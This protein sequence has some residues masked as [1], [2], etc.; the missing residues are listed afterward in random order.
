MGIKKAGLTKKRIFI[1][2]IIF[3]CLIFVDYVGLFESINHYLYDFSFRIRGERE[4]SR[5]IILV[6]ID[7]RTLERLGRWPI[8]R[9]FYATLIERLKQSSAIMIDIIMTEPTKDDT[10]LSET[11]KRHGKVFLPVY[12]DEERKI[13]Y[14]SIHNFLGYT[15]H[16]H[17]EQDIDGVVRTVYHTLMVDNKI[18]PS[19]ASSLYELLTGKPFKREKIGYGGTTEGKGKIL[20]FDKMRINFAGGHGTF[21]TISFIDVLDGIY[22]PDFFKNRIVIVGL[23]ATGT[24]DVMLTPFIKH[25]K[26]MPGME[27]QA[28]ILNTLIFDNAIMDIKLWIR[29]LIAL[30]IAFIFHIFFMAIDEKKGV[31]IGFL[32]IVSILTGSYFLFTRFNI[33]L[34]PT[35]YM[36]SVFLFF[37]ISYVYKFDDAVKSLHDTYTTLKSH[38]RWKIIENEGIK[39]QRGILSILS[40][41]GINAQAVVLNEIGRQLNFEKELSDRALMSGTNGV[42]LFEENG[43]NML[44]NDFG[45]NILKALN[46]E[47]TTIYKFIEAIFPYLL[48]KT[49]LEAVKRLV[50]DEK[51]PSTYTLGTTDKE[52]KFYKIDFSS[53]NI[54]GSPYFLVIITDIT[55]I[56]ELELLKSHIISVVSH[57]LKGPMTS[58]QGFSEILSKN[59]TG[60]MQNFAHIINRESERLVRFLNT[61]L[62]ITRIEEGRQPVRISPVNLIEV[63]KE[64]AHASTP[65][66]DTNKISI[67]TEVPERIEDIMIDRDLT[68][69][70]IFNLVEN[71]IK[72]SPPERDVI[73]RLTDE[74]YDVRVDVIDHGYG[75]REED[76]GRIFDKFFRSSSPKTKNIKGSGLGL[77]FVKEAVELQGGRLTL[78]SKYNEGS[79]FSIIF[80]KKGQDKIKKG[81]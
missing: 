28:N 68:K 14:P 60:K 19:I 44:T 21:D 4:C 69:Q 43:N 70:C 33:W 30:L 48:E 25:R 2:F 78:T 36:T 79:V 54:A 8:K 35:V 65:I 40:K 39:T 11:I 41:K 3:A 5:D 16:I 73:I 63:I 22:P 34:S 62:D 17:V 67:H 55:K 15:G 61:F 12:I 52:K 26:G 9:S 6:T 72:Y 66:G 31:I 7:D 29:W 45:M 77:T 42:L 81:D 57:E 75:I 18:V 58:I 37:V 27:V 24:F 53:F 74:G 49:D 20:Q 46:V 23:A 76:M 10:V 80:P 38:L 59:L 71:A 51:R 32:S 56:K 1:S 50:I 47:I 64:V 13:K